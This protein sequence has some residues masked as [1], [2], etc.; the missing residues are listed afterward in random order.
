M[1]K[2]FYSQLIRLIKQIQELKKNLNRLY[3]MMIIQMKA[4][5]K[6]PLQSLKKSWINGKKPS[7]GYQKYN[8]RHWK[9]F[10]KCPHL[11]DQI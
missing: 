5:L 7:I 4:C 10:Q 1:S 2:T 8:G 3:Y 6:K 9:D 11:T